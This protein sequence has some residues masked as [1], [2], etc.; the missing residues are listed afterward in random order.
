MA[1][2]YVINI[3][4][5]S[6]YPTQPQPDCVFQIAWVMSGTDGNG[7]NAAAYGTTEVTYDPNEPYIPYPD[8]TQD[9]V[10]GWVNEYTPA[11]QIT[12]AQASI[13]EQIAAQQNPTTV[14][15]PLPW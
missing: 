12:A 3:N 9:H 15:P 11:D 13:D 4:S 10:V 7:H 14:Q 5:L 2:T 1:N 6:C 8:L